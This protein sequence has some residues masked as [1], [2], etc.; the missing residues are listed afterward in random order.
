MK[1][2]LLVFSLF[3]TLETDA[4]ITK[5]KEP[6]ANTFSIVARDMK[7]G[8]M[9]VGVQSHL[10]SVGTTVSWGQ[11]GV[12]VI[13]T[14]SFANKSFGIRGLNLMKNGK[15]ADEA[16]S[17]L[18]SGDTDKEVRQVAIADAKGN[19]AVFTGKN[20]VEYAGH[21]KGLNFSVQSNMMLNNKVPEA[22]SRAFKENW[23]LPLPERVMKTLEAGRLAS[24]SIKGKQSAALLV[25]KGTASNK[26]WD[27]DHLI[28]LRVD[29]K[30]MPLA[31]LSR[32]LKVKRAYEHLNAGDYAIASSNV[33]KAMDEYHAAIKLLPNSAEMQYWTAISM[34]NNNDIKKSS[35]MLQKIY[36]KEPNWRELTKRLTK[37]GLLNVS[38]WELKELVK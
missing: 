10:F 12:G 15:T 6:F 19:I 21:V 2:L 31:E 33:K 28:D 34:A 20:C 26:P 7:T 1:K 11:A 16:L 29:D 37:V 14:Q 13:A 32:L 18:L 35:Q 36:S 22:M 8:E 38:E 30:E 3:F 17:I 9:A 27:D 4:Q 5:N 25:V 23:K 24:G